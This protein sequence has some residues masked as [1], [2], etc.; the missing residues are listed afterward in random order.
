MSSELISRSPDLKSL[1]D[2]GFELSILDGHLLITNVPYVTTQRE[3]RRGDLI[4]PLAMAGDVTAKP[5]KHVVYFRG[6]YPCH[7]EGAPIEGVRHG[8]RAERSPRLIADFSFS[9]KPPNGFTDYNQLVRNYVNIISGPAES[10]D[11]TATAQTY[12]VVEPEADESPFRYIDTATSR[13]GLGMASRA[14]AQS[15]V[16]I[17]GLGGTG[18]YV[19]DL[20]AKTPVEFLHL[21]D[22]DRFISHNAFRAPG[23]A[24]LEE[25]RARASKVSYF[26]ERYGAM[27]RNI[28]E[29]PVFVDATNIQELTAMDFVFIC[30][31]KGPARRLIV[32][33]LLEAKVPFIDTGMGVEQSGHQL[34]A[35]L[36]VTTNTS[37]RPPGFD[38]RSHMDRS[39]RE[40]VDD[41]DTNIQVA[42]LNALNAAL[43]VV[44]WKK[45]V[46]FYVDHEREHHSTYTTN[47]NL[48]T[49]EGCP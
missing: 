1:Y 17:V 20:V 42:D 37:V 4:I 31:D 9:N 32:D 25:V 10:L 28:V 26:A 2:D 29:H 3:I 34:F 45:A 7:R 44:R 14:L 11:P 23:A 47:M 38:V 16:A 6:E 49:G 12:R 39:D 46:G 43:A 40:A 19:L 30:V 18:A 21:F 5:P 35:T 36:R 48:L 15:N 24:S 41:Y 22:G 33:A 8:A 13:A 27:R